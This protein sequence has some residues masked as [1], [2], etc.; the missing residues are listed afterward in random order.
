MNLNN[1]LMI[2]IKKLRKFNKKYQEFKSKITI[3]QPN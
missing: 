3:Y 1:R 2:K